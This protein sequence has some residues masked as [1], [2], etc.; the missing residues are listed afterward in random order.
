MSDDIV[1][2]RP[3]TAA[4]VADL[5]RRAQRESLTIT[6]V[7]GGHGPWS[8]AREPGMRIELGA[9][10]DI[11]IEG[12]ALDGDDAVVHIGGGAVWGDVA[13]TLADDGLAISSGDTASVG[14][15]GLT[16]GGGI[17]W[18][19]RSWGLAADQLVGAQVVTATGDIVEVSADEN[20]D[21]FWALRGG[22]GNFGIVTRF[23]FRAHPINGIAF[24]EHVIDEDA[25]GVMRAM[26]DLMH[27]APRELTVTYMDVPP[28]D[29]S[30]P[31]GA[32]ISAVWADADPERLRQVMAPVADLDGVVAEYTTPVY[33]DILLEMPEPPEGAEAPPGF[34][35]GNGLFAELDDDLID[36]LVA[37]RE[38]YPASVVFLRSLGG[39]YGDV[40]QES[41]AF[42]A[43][44]AN[45][46]VMAGG[47]D[48]PGVIDDAARAAIRADWERM[49]AGRLAE[50]GNFADTERPDA[51]PGMFTPQAHERLR[52]IKAKW[53]PQN[54]FR[55][56]HNIAV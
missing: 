8:Q 25:G 9:L 26:R 1:T 45:W 47:F 49:Q 7:A 11:E 12:L 2:T 20:P 16:L 4:E 33:R 36:R 27:D 39:A 18:M 54:V 43:R 22:G 28:M 19:V 31:A 17:G 52:T 5:V 56:N 14:V 41:A 10:S 40:P 50:Y 55:R 30:A 42:P 13:A 32:R 38:A 24:G 51:V 37:F 48:I 21:L 23:D 46:F 44:E 15:G 29:P 35:G 53:D 6:V 3:T 34:I